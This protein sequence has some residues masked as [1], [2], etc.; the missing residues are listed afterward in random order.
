MHACSCKNEQSAAVAKDWVQRVYTFNGLFT[1][2]KQIWKFPDIGKYTFSIIT[3][4]ILKSI[5]SAV[6]ISIATFIT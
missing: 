6:Y 3:E 4:K 1:S 5:S 2:H